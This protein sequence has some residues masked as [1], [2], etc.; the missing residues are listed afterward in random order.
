M[1]AVSTELHFQ[2]GT[3]VNDS[4]LRETSYRVKISEGYIKMKFDR[5]SKCITLDDIQTVMISLHN[6]VEI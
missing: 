1:I 4:N 3:R 5:F 6:T 2:G